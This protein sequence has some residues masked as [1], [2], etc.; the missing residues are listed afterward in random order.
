MKVKIKV[1]PNAVK[2]EIIKVK[3]GEYKVSLREKAE[4]NKAN[5]GLLKLLKKYFKREIRIIKGLKTRNKV[6]EVR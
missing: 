1:K 6:V 4:N 3:E 5:I 2:Q